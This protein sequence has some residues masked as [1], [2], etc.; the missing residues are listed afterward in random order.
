MNRFNTRASRLAVAALAAGLALTGCSAGQVS[1]SANQEP[2]VNG[3][4]DSVGDIALRNIFVRAPQT[5]DYVQPGTD[6]E[7]LFAAANNSADVADKLVSVTSDIGTVTLSGDTA[8]PANGLLLVGNPDNHDL[9]GTIE[10]EEEAEAQVT[11]AEP[12]TNGLMYDFT[13]TFERAGSTTVA[14]PIS[15]GEVPRRDGEPAPGR[16]SGGGHGGGH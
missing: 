8:I 3:T 2:A 6:V 12:I 13:F 16:N 5:S 10:R 14:V 4:V 7:L 15:A 1:Q 9:L 11:L